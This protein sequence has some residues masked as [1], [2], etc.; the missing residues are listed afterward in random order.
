MDTNLQKSKETAILE[1]LIQNNYKAAAQNLQNESSNLRGV[2]IESN[3]N[4]LL[5]KWQLIYSL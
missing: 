4:L 5:N 3:Q 1:Y 2:F